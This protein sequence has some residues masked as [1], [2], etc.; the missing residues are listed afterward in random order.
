MIKSSKLLV[1]LYW[2]ILMLIWNLDRLLR[3]KNMTAIEL[4]KISNVHPNVL[5]RIRQN[6]QRR[7][8]LDV[9]ERIADSLGVSLDELII[10]QK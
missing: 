5:S 4:A 9:L 2:V 1:K 7:I 10:K 6:Q 8:E 3:E